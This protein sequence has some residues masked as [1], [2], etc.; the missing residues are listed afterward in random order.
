MQVLPI[1]ASQMANRNGLAYSRDTLTDPRYN[2]EFG[3]SFIELMRSNSGTAGQLPR[4]IASYN[5]GPLPVGRWASINDKGDPLLWIESIPYWETRY[6]VPA[7]MRNMWV[8]Q[9]LN[10]EATTTLT[11]LAEHRWPTFPT[12]MTRLSH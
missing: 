5:A 11:S 2:L 3:Q 9:G 7:V 8:Y 10:G 12:S 4:V 6:Y 1:T